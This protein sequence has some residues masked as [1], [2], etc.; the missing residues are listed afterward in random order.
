M[1]V[2]GLSPIA[3]AIGLIVGITM[4]GSITFLPISRTWSR[5]TRLVVGTGWGII[6]ATFVLTI[7][8]SV[9]RPIDRGQSVIDNTNAV[10]K[11][12]IDEINNA[13]NGF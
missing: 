5:Q 6:V 1:T 3:W 8:W 7:A 4:A 10:T 13:Q 11:S 12:G 2:F 9:G